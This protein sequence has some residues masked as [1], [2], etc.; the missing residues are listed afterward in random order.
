MENCIF[1]KIIRGDAAS[2][3][4]AENDDILVI[5][6]IAPKA[7]IHYLLIPK[8]HVRDIQ[9]LQADELGYGT[10]LFAMAQHLS[11][12]IPEAHD[13]KLHVNSGKKR[14]ATRDAFTY[15]FHRWQDARFYL[16]TRVQIMDSEYEIR[17]K[18]APET[19]RSRPKRLGRTDAEA[20]TCKQVMIH[21]VEGS[22][23]LY[24]VAGRII[25]S[26]M[27]GKAGFVT[28][29]DRSGRVQLHFKEEILGATAFKE[30]VDYIDLG[31]I[32]GCKAPILEQKWVKLRACHLAWQL[33]TKCLHPLPEKFHG[34]ADIETK[35]RQRYLDLLS[36]PETRERLS[37]VRKSLKKCVPI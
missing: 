18:K 11:K 5:Q 36:S 26:R 30:F 12:I 1:C 7:P 37:N 27:Q 2:K 16:I 17:V 22:E 20:N 13:F 14:G 33:L 3:I 24:S 34:I 4:I 23:K 28:I 25:T 29:Q 21:F 15:A 32:I 6:D 10:K 31:D 19:Y 35:Y 9:T 8:M